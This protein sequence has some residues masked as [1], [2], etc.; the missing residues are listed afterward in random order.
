MQRHGT[1][2]IRIYPSCDWTNR[3]L[4]GMR[5][6]ICDS[7]SG[8]SRAMLARIFEPFFTTKMETGTGLGLWVVAQLIERRK[9]S[10]HVWSSQRPGASGT[11]FSA[12]MP[13]EN[14]ISDHDAG[15]GREEDVPEPQVRR[16][17]TFV[18]WK[19]LQHQDA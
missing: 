1:L 12:F 4:Q 3:S 19:L 10:M 17:E 18:P 6:T 2:R 8:I 11:A 15:E 5:V 9:G 13:F 16:T 7:G 14:L